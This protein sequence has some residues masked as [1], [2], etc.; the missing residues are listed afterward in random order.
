M[1]GNRETLNPR[2]KRAS[3]GLRS[4]PH[5]TLFPIKEPVHGLLDRKTLHEGNVVEQIVPHTF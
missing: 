1:R 3:D 5:F 2:A 4:L